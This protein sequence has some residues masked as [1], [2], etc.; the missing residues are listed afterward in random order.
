MTH[1]GTTDV[2]D[3]V[4]S[5]QPGDRLDQL[6]SHRPA[7]REN[8]Q[9]AYEAIFRPTDDAGF[10]RLHRFAV[11]Y[12]VA[13]LHGFEPVTAFYRDE[14][15]GLDRGED[16]AAQLDGIAGSAAANGPFGHFSETGLRHRDT[17]GLR[18]E[19]TQEQRDDLGQALSVALEHAHA[20]VLRPREAS[21]DLLERLTAA[22]WDATG[23]VVLSQLVAFLAFQIRLAAGLAAL[24]STWSVAA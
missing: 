13:K 24:R 15:R 14:L 17:D 12:L 19:L 23:T 16:L 8:A 7:A 2:L 3:A 11:A 10:S 20:L 4:L 6:R 9:K 5:V 22:G 21:P 1:P 18:F